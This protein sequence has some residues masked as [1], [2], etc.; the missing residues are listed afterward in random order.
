VF[1][2][3][4]NMGSGIVD[5]LKELGH[6]DIVVGVNSASSALDSEKYANKRAEMWGM[7]YEWLLDYPCKIPDDDELHADLCGIKAKN[8]SKSRVLME[9]KED[10][11][12]RRIRSP[13]LADALCLTF[14]APESAIIAAQESQT[15]DAA[16][17]FADDLRRRQNL[18]KSAWK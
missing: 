17:M 5:R 18:K 3:V 16:K 14:A 13:D 9:R 1:I 2:D 12:K 4:G 6:A 15:N 7:L 10:M 8:D 11:A